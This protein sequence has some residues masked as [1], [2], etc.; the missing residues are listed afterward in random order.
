MLGVAKCPVRLTF[1]N[2][3]HLF[4]RASRLSCV[5]QLTRIARVPC[6]NTCSLPWCI[7][8]CPST[9]QLSGMLEKPTIHKHILSITQNS[10]QTHHHAQL[11]HL[12]FVACTAF[13]YKQD[14]RCVLT[15]E[16]FSLAHQRGILGIVLIVNMFTMLISIQLR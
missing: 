10:S 14:R 13:T 16:Q 7:K 9:S 15:C 11:L 8:E 1:T 2:M 5:S 12:C 4:P 6:I 3:L